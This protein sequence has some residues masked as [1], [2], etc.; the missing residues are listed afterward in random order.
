M[1]GEVDVAIGPQSQIIKAGERIEGVKGAAV[2]IAT[3]VAQGG[4]LAQD[5]EGDGGA[6]GPL[7]LRHSSDLLLVEEVDEFVSRVANRIHNVNITPRN[8]LS[9]VIFT[10]KGHRTRDTANQNPPFSIEYLMAYAVVRRW[11]PVPKLCALSV[12]LPI[13]LCTNP[14]VVLP[15]ARK[16]HPIQLPST[17]SQMKPDQGQSR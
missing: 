3:A 12:F 14:K 15:S 5:G 1:P 10:F 4:Q 8:P 2:G 11:G 17:S 9:S 16:R 6:Q 13:S 7:E